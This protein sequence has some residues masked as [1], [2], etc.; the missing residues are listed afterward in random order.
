MQS[1]E[2][3][4]EGAE[5]RRGPQT[6]SLCP[7]LEPVP[8]GNG[9]LREPHVQSARGVQREARRPRGRWWPVESNDAGAV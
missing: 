3:A 5:T 1:R 2:V 9:K 8:S 6:R 4:A 7:E